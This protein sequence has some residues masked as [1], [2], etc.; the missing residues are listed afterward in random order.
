[1]KVRLL[2]SQFLLYK[3]HRDK[4]AAGQIRQGMVVAVALTE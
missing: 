4:R 1:M 2:V 3:R